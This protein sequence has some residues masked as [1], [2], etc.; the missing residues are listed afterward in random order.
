MGSPAGSSPRSPDTH[1]LRRVR[2][3]WFKARQHALDKNNA[4]DIRELRGELAKIEVV[5]RDEKKR[6]YWRLTGNR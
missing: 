3:R 2:T 1:D 6:Q 5:V 4:H